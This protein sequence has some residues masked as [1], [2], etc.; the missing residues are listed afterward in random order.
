MIFRLIEVPSQEYSIATDRWAA[1]MTELGLR[2]WN[3]QFSRTQ[4][5]PS[6]RGLI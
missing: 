6:H 3:L 4:G 2:R 1:K 5:A